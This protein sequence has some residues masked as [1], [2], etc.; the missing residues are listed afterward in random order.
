MLCFGIAMSDIA[1]SCGEL[2]CYMKQENIGK[3]VTLILEREKMTDC[4]VYAVGEYT[5]R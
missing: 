3:R 2:G 5:C 4:Y 1:L